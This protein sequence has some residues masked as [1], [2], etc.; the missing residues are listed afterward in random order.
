VSA[1]SAP[2]RHDPARVRRTDGPAPVP[3]SRTP[4]RDVHTGPHGST[5]RPLRRGRRSSA[6]RSERAPRASRRQPRAPAAPALPPTPGRRAPP[7]RALA[8]R[9][10]PRRGDRDLH[11]RAPAASSRAGH[12]HDAAARLAG[13]AH[14][15]RAG[16]AVPGFR[17]RSGCRVWSGCRARSGC[18]AR[19]PAGAVGSR[20]GAV[21]GA[22]R[23]D[24]APD[25]PAAGGAAP[26][27]PAAEAGADPPRA[28]AGHA[29]RG[30]PARLG[31]AAARALRP[32]PTG[33]F[34]SSR[35]RVALPNVL[36]AIRR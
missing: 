1:S 25:R 3:R 35:C 15:A 22:H 6:A 10:R 14:G 34:R 20:S 16:A 9:R 21:V 26:G 4:G 33:T 12:G 8:R 23:A 32:S 11:G 29:R 13:R 36:L 19:R 30:A 7:A 2:A 27:G 24:P 31:S 17:V 5:G 28:R 18:C